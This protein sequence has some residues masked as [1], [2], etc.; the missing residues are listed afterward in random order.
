MMD[1]LADGAGP[2]RPDFS[3]ALPDP[4]PQARKRYLAADAV[5]RLSRSGGRREPGRTQ[6]LLEIL[7][8]EEADHLSRLRSMLYGMEADR[9]AVAKW[10]RSIRRLVP[11]GYLH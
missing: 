4:L 7:R 3:A 5:A 10:L 11:A 2:A 1:G 6:A 8:E 9:P